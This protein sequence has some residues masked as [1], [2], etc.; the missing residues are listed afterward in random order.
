MLVL[1]LLMLIYLDAVVVS[2]LLELFHPGLELSE[3]FSLLSLDLLALLDLVLQ[4]IYLLLQESETLG[5]VVNLRRVLLRHAPW[6]HGYLPSLADES[7]HPLL[8]LDLLMMHLGEG[9]LVLLY[10]L[11]SLSDVSLEVEEEFGALDLF[12]ALL[13]PLMLLDQVGYSLICIFDLLLPRANLLR[14]RAVRVLVAPKAGAIGHLL[15]FETLLVH[16]VD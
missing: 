1:V 5:R 13:D 16:L 4:L 11:L 12:E 7:I 2:Y 15:L 14:P 10:L 9:L 6:S 3:V 8:S